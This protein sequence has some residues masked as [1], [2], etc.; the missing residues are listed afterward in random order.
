[1]PTSERLA[2]LGDE[3]RGAV[4]ESLGDWLVTIAREPGTRRVVDAAASRALEA[5]ERRPWGDVVGSVRA[6]KVAAF[7]AGS[8]AS[9]PG[10]RVVET[11]VRGLVERLL[12]QPIGRPA[13]WIGPQMRGTLR[14]GLIE[15]AWRWVQAQ[16]PRL[17]Q[18]IR[19]QEIIEQKV[20]D[21][22]IERVEHLIRDVSQKELDL[23][24]KIGYVL[25]GVFGFGA[26]WLG[27]LVGL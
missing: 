6:E 3:R 26:F 17:V 12:D 11:V 19:V 2:R 15:E 9:E 24:V 7:A 21:L 25:G 20:N 1:V 13:E 18:Q 14:E 8:L 10:Q 5:L 16:M 27:K 23:I 22:P 4:A